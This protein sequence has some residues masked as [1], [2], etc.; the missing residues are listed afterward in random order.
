MD[1]TITRAAVFHQ[2]GDDLVQMDE[3]ESKPLPDPDHDQTL[4]L[5]TYQCAEDGTVVSVGST[6]S[7]TPVV[8]APDEPV[9]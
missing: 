7:V 8:I 3:I 5:V 9:H 1:I 4:T 2:H 6:T